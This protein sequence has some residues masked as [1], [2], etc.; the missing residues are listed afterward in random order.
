VAGA[1]LVTALLPGPSLW[2]PRGHGPLE[3]PPPNPQGLPAWYTCQVSVWV[4]VQRPI[5]GKS[6]TQGCG[7]WMPRG[8]GPPNCFQHVEVPLLCWLAN[9]CTQGAY[10]PLRCLGSAPHL[11]FVL[12]LGGSSAGLN[13]EALRIDRAQGAIR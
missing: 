5:R 12:D 4:S 9:C 13:R 3:P 11:P 10:K 6:L 7:R 8:K 1:N 2:E